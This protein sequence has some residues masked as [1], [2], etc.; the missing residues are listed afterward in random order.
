MTKR[1]SW[2]TALHVQITVT[3]EQLQQYIPQNHYLFQGVYRE[4][5]TETRNKT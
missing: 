5:V 3:T 4:E 1:V 2:E